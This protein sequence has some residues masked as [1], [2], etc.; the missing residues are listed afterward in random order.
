MQAQIQKDLEKDFTA[1]I[2]TKFKDFHTD[3]KD[4]FAKLNTWYDDLHTMVSDLSNTVKMLMKQQQ[5]MHDTL[6]SIQN[7]LTTLSSHRG[8]DG[9]A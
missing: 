1:L 7:N 2:Y 5:H 9:C 4:S 3:V 6:D 8:G